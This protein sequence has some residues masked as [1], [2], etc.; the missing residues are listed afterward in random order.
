MRL[1]FLRFCLGLPTFLFFLDTDGYNLK[2]SFLNIS[3]VNY[4]I[5]GLITTDGYCFR[6]T[7]ISLPRRL[8][9][10]LWLSSPIYFAFL[11]LIVAHSRFPLIP[12]LSIS[13]ILSLTVVRIMIILWLPIINPNRTVSFLSIFPLHTLKKILWEDDYSL[14]LH[15]CFCFLV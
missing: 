3:L 2:H 4:Y 12:C 5:L 10:F 6:P 15:A 13:N 8:T 11:Q 1:F 9:R 14:T 7:F